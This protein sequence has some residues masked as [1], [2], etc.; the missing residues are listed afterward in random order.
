V[1]DDA[2]RQSEPAMMERCAQPCRSVREV[3]WRCLL[4]AASGHSGQVPC[5]NVRE[6]ERRCVL[7]RSQR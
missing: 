4:N 7:S 2:S 5:H 3:D 6:I 1:L